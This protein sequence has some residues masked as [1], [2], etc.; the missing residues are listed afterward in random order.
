[1]LIAILVFVILIFLCVVSCAGSLQTLVK[2][3]QQELSVWQDPKK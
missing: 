1:M 2:L 3:R